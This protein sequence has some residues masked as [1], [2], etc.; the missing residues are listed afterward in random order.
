MIAAIE[1]GLVNNSLGGSSPR[2]VLYK[3]DLYNNKTSI[4]GSLRDQSLATIE[5]GL[6][7]RQPGWHIDDWATT[8]L[9]FLAETPPCNDKAT[10]EGSWDGHVWFN[11][12]LKIL[13]WSQWKAI[14]LL[15]VINNQK[16]MT[17][18]HA[19]KV[20]GNLEFVLVMVFPPYRRILQSEKCVDCANQNFLVCFWYNRQTKVLF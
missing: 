9:R 19:F 10:G 15:T 13:P 8:N 2:P 4:G 3:L 1:C 7:I 14:G 18:C 16:T 12:Y 6:N 11:I 20:G 17:N 5:G